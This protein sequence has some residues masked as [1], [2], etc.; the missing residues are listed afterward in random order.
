LIKKLARGKK[1][2]TKGEFGR[3][4]LMGGVVGIKGKRRSFNAENDTN[5]KQTIR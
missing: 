1:I 5:T 4:D 2:A 3:R